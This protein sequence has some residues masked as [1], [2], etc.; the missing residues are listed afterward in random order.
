MTPVLVLHVMD[1]FTVAGSGPHGVLKL[2][3]S[4]GATLP[5]SE[6]RFHLVGLRPNPP[7]FRLP[8]ET[9]FPVVTLNRGKFDPRTLFQLIRIV[10]ELRPDVLHLHGYASW[11]FG[12]L[13]GI[14]TRTPVV[15][16]EHMVH[17]SSP[18]YQRLSDRVLS[19]LPARAVAISE[20]VRRFMETV[21][22][23]RRGT[24]V[25]LP[26]GVPLDQ[27]AVPD[28]AVVDAARRHFGLNGKT[29]VIG[30]VGRLDPVKGQDVLI[31]AL[32]AVMARFPDLKVLI[33][34]DGPLEPELRRLS[35]E[36]GIGSRVLFLGYRQDLPKLLALMDVFVV[37][38]RSEGFCIAAVEA[39]AAG[40]AIVST[41]CEALAQL[42]REGE[43]AV[44]CRAGDPADLAAKL[45]ALLGDESLRRR[46]AARA[47]Q[48]SSRFDIRETAQAYARLYR[49]TVS[50]S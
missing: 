20:A 44:L 29:L 50:T 34:G 30:T 25:V 32:P 8:P 47:R 19:P 28:P 26:N 49:D 31:R 39:M 9:S 21:R 15:L 45:I 41:D 1:K 38:S 24:L 16:Q 40:R 35:T 10:R 7:G 46:L 12:R 48:E 22:H 37:P 5:S 14:L 4:L 6:I 36:L 33:I 13:A 11:T 2:V 27:F 3:T 17:G 43:S 18:W 42:F 23:V